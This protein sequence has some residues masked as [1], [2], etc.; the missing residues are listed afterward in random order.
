MYYYPG[1]ISTEGIGTAQYNP[2][3]IEK[4]K[5]AVIRLPILTKIE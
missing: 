4:N 2:M 3:G 5:A 1:I